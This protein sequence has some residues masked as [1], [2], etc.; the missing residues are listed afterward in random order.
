MPQKERLFLSL[1]LSV[2]TEVT[3]PVVLVKLVL[4]RSCFDIFYV[5]LI[6]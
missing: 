4:C 1:V 6:I 5:G 3:D 2:L